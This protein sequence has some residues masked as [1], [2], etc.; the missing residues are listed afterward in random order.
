MF[1]PGSQA[2]MAMSWADTTATLM[3]TSAEIS[4]ANMASIT[5][6]WCSASGL[7]PV[8]PSKAV[9][10]VKPWYRAPEPAAP[11]PFGF[12]PGAMTMPSNPIAASPAWPQLAFGQLPMP[13]ATGSWPFAVQSPSN[14]YAG[15]VPALMALVMLGAAAQ[16]ALGLIETA[17]SWQDASAHIAPTMLPSYRSDSGHAVANVFMGQAAGATAAMP[18]DGLAVILGYMRAIS[19]R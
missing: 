18:F 10:T 6:F 19:P 13:F 4:A 17:R 11:S 2:R 5:D 14:A 9:S 3:R 15:A 7:K 16:Q 1:D 8:Q 12:W